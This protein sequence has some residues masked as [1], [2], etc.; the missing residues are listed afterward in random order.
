MKQFY[1]MGLL[2]L[3]LLFPFS[4]KAQNDYPYTINI[5]DP[6]HVIVTIDDVVQ[7]DLVAGDNVMPATFYASIVFEAA[8]GYVLASVTRDGTDLQ[9]SA[10]RCSTYFMGSYYPDAVYKV[11]T[12]AASEYYKG[13]FTLTID[14]PSLVDVMFQGSYRTVT[15]FEANEPKTVLYNPETESMLSL[16]AL[17]YG[18]AIYEVH[19]DGEKADPSDDG[20]YNIILAQDMNIQVTA[21]F[22]DIDTPVKFEFVNEGT[23]G[24]IYEVKV[25]YGDPIPADE[26]LADGFGLKLGSSLNVSFNTS[27]Y[28]VNTVYINDVQQYS[29]YSVN[30]VLVGPTVIKIDA[31][32]YELVTKAVHVEGAEH[33]TLYKGSSWQ[34]DI[35]EL[36]DGDNTITFSE[37]DPGYTFELESGYEFTVLTDGEVDLLKNYSKYNNYF[38]L[39]SDG[40]L[41]IKVGKIVFPET[42]YIYLAGLPEEAFVTLT[43][44][45]REVYSGFELSEGYND[46]GFKSE[47]M[48]PFNLSANFRSGGTFDVQEVYVDGEKAEPT[49][50]GTA[51]YT[52]ALSGGS[53][54]KAYF[55]EAPAEHTVNFT[56]DEGL[57]PVVT[58]DIIKTHDD[59]TAPLKALTGTLVK[60]EAP[61]GVDDLEIKIGEGE[62]ETLTSKEFTVNADTDVLISKK[63][64]V[65]NVTVAGAK[66]GAVY[67]L[68]GIR[69]ADAADFGRLP[70]GVYIVDG[71]KTYKK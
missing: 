41:T 13:S 32:A 47:T 64:G 58:Y 5:D 51:V 39:N 2:L 18:S 40:D 70:A 28:K 61:E 20:T 57:A 23:E 19:I 55:K 46:I 33:M 49:Y 7:T 68:Q 17:N 52:M 8:D 12:M 34:N 66:A 48:S 16:K 24:V 27:D 25:G 35:V 37:N 6:T 44:Y 67:N 36:H 22:P 54:V 53:V 50:E 43:D 29:T 10:T 42:A 14:D 56:V 69:V 30:V 11:T 31:K 60:V 62:P 63:S 1:A 45:Y 38:S 4:M 71:V 65:S 26:Y 15:N 3:T 21:L 9:P 59:L